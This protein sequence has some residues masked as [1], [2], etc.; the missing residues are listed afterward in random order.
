V[1]LGHHRPRITI[2]LW[3]GTA[4]EAPGYSFEGL[5]DKEVSKT[6]LAKVLPEGG[7]MR[8]GPGRA[9]V[10]A[11]FFGLM[12]SLFTG[13]AS[14][15]ATA[16]IY[17]HVTYAS[18]GQ[19]IRVYLW[20]DLPDT[21]FD[22]Y[23]TVIRFNPSDLQLQL[24]ATEESVMTT[25]CSNRWWYT[26]PGSGTILVSHVRMCPPNT[27]VTGPG[28]LSSLSFKVLRQGRIV[29]TRDYF[30]FTRA[31]YWIKDVTWEDGLVL[32][33][34]DPA[35]VGKD[36]G[37]DGGNSYLRVIPNPGK[38]FKFDQS[39]AAGQINIYDITGRL[40]RALGGLRDPGGASAPT[41]DGRDLWD[42]ACPPGVYM[43]V[44]AGSEPC[45]QPCRIVIIR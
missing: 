4:S 40:V 3:F 25:N 14:A 29:I 18:P 37:L 1:V 28:A 12:V 36:A 32:A 21:L 38:E 41:W 45:E 13:Q 22:G 8:S 33:G 16:S 27:L 35:D 44:P 26:S 17:P 2:I 31:G 34:G 43:A 24:S 10:L 15:G 23:E 30:W 39:P 42:R 5:R 20:K 9:V 6:G 7:C 19:V 11:V